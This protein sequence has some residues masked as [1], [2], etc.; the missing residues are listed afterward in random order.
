MRIYFLSY[1]PAI[2]KLN[3]LYLGGVDLFERHVEISLKDCVHAEIVPGENL[4][5]VNFF[6]DEKL[7]S[8]PPPFL[9][10]Y[11]MDG[12]ALIFVREFGNKDAGLNI[13]LQHRFCGQLVTVFSQ[14][15]VYLTVD[16]GDYN[17]ERLPQKFIAARAEEEKIGGLPVLAL[18]GAGG[19]VILS[20][21]GKIIF[22]NDVLSAEFGERL[23][24]EVAFETCTAAKAVCEYGYDGE[25]L[26]LV[27]S[28]TV[29]QRTE[30]GILHFAFF[31]SVLCRGGYAEYLSEELK[32]KAGEIFDYL[33]EFVSVVVPTER[34]FC[35]HEGVRAAGLVYPKAKNLFEVKYFAVDLDGDNKI[36]NIYPI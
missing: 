5:S 32:A 35:L 7:L 10:I 29:E 26:S 30:I 28:E 19:L 34:F 12:E 14:G 1:K 9:D 18:Y 36:E 20:D 33:G 13:I 22:S 17:L 24:V 15:A 27:K 25:R 11:L 21:R 31:E 4:Q 3:G 8:T 2:L 23:K 16:G 6:I